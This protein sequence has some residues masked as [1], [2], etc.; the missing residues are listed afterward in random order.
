MG[1]CPGTSSC[2]R[3]YPSWPGSA[4]YPTSTPELEWSSNGWK[5]DG[6]K[7]KSPVVATYTAGDYW[8]ETKVMGPGKL[9]FKWKTS[10]LYYIRLIFSYFKGEEKIDTP[11]ANNNKSFAEEKTIQIVEE[12]E[13]R[14]RWTYQIPVL[15]TGTAW[16]EQF[17][18][19]PATVE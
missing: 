3:G 15:G 9:T 13:I 5:S 16:L 2:D 12:G 4:A 11:F 17:V 14:L 1:T 18:F 8:I 10:S 6:D 7:A 19:T